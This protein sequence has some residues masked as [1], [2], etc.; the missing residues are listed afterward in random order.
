LLNP[1]R[2]DTHAL[3]AGRSLDRAEITNNET[4]SRVGWIGRV[5]KVLPGKGHAL[6]LDSEG[7]GGAAKISKK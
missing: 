5:G 2:L 1:K 6:T 3:W 7:L 4:L